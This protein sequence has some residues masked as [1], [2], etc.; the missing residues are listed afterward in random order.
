M[1]QVPYRRLPDQ[2]CEWHPGG[3]ENRAMGYVQWHADAEERH[4][5]GEKQKKCRECGYYI[6]ESLFGRKP[7]A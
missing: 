1:K 6:W 7:R 3:R 2:P 4:K 5:A